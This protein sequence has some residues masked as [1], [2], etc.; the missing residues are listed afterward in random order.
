VDLRSF[1]AALVPPPFEPLV[2]PKI[3]L[4]V[5]LGRAIDLINPALGAHQKR[6]ALA[7]ANLAEALDLGRNDIVRTVMAS[8]L[9][10]VGA[11]SQS[12]LHQS[13]AIGARFLDI[14]PFT[15]DL[16]P[17]VAASRDS[18]REIDRRLGLSTG[19]ALIAQSIHLASH[20]DERSDPATFVLAQSARCGED[21]AVFAGA[22]LDPRV[23]AAFARASRNDSFWLDACDFDI[24][25]RVRG[26]LAAMADAMADLDELLD[27]ARLYSILVDSR[28]PY[29]ATHSWGVAAVANFLAARSGID[30]MSSQRI[31]IAAQLHDIGKLV[32][33]SRIIEKP[34]GLTPEEFGAVRGHAYFTGTLL[35]A[36][37]GLGRIAEW[38][39][40]HHEKLDGTGYP[41]GLAGARVGQET[42]II[43]VADQ[44]VA[45]TEDRP[46]R[47][48][49][50]GEDAIRILS[51]A[52]ESGAVD[53]QIASIIRD[54][55]AT[56]DAIRRHAQGVERDEIKSI[57]RA[58]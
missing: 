44:F 49:L 25:A 42:R 16:A 29:T 10:G 45:L 35:A 23:A 33:P 41:M 36:I 4:V 40:G 7:A 58:A 46:Y 31:E 28:S 21:A 30:G 48:G 19:D 57:L 14:S 13:A 39:R 51:G 8:L 15:R 5:A 1:P 32:V 54:D 38:A 18:L 50:S 22:Q 34:A 26:R 27:F 53:R 47:S 55:F 11:L 9:Q 3:E 43:S 2:V 24:D 20:I 17:I 6:V 52:A 37:P 12:S 56:V